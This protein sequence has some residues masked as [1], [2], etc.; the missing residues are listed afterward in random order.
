M[1]LE[2][3][4]MEAAVSLHCLGS[5]KAMGIQKKLSPVFDVKTE[6]IL[7]LSSVGSNALAS[8]L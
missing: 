5:R 7:L 4:H 2:S 3:L 8:S 1:H 6:N